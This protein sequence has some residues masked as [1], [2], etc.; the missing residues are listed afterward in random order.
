[1]RVK[2]VHK[3]GENPNNGT[4]DHAE[5][6]QKPSRA[7]ITEAAAAA[8]GSTLRDVPCAA[9]RTQRAEVTGLPTAREGSARRLGWNASAKPNAKAHT[10]IGTFA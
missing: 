1:M 5:K 3:K 8:C 4:C 9:C 6:Q 10:A 7:T 2:K